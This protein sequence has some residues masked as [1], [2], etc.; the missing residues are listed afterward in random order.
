[1]KAS[2]WSANDS[3]CEICG[4]S[5]NLLSEIAEMYNPDDDDG[6]IICHVRCGVRND[7]CVERM[8]HPVA[9]D[10]SVSS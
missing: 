8:V 3:L 7:L 1:M 6:S 2:Y 10:T 4:V 5:F 9:A